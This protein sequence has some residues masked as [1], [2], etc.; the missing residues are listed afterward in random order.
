MLPDSLRGWCGHSTD[1]LPAHENKRSLLNFGGTY[2][3]DT[4][5]AD[6]TL[7][8]IGRWH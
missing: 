7:V 2:D 6:T 8:D 4:F 3:A 1:V 5:V